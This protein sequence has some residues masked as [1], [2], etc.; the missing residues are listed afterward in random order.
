MVM[1]KQLQSFL[2][3]AALCFA[4]SM[5][6][7]QSAPKTQI[8]LLSDQS[9][10]TPGSQV[11]VGIHFQ[12]EPGWHIYWMNPGDAGQPPSVQWALPAGWSAGAIEWPAPERL[13]NAAGVDY[14]YNGE[15]TLL[16][17]VKVPA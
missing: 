1:G 16:T 11:W 13:T 9:A 3:G 5:A 10:V 14:G 7:A 8:S 15:A 4:G 12:L 2:L 17:K 6:M